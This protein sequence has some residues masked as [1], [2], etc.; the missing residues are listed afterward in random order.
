MNKMFLRFINFPGLLVLTLMGIG[1]QTSLFSFWP[2]NYLQ[3]DIVLFIVVWA[4]LRRNFW[5]GGWIT[6]FVADFA[7]LHSAA[8]QG[9]FMI[10]YMLVFLLVRG[11]S[12]L[13]VI[14]NLYSSSS[15]SSTLKPSK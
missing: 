13:V 15:Q 1:I 14:P 4:A 6:L 8:P 5:E 3:P 2:L 9:M 12:R 10:T 7:E 11:L